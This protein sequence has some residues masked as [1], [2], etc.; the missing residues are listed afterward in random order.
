MEFVNYY[1]QSTCWILTRFLT[2]GNDIINEPSKVF[3]HVIKSEPKRDK[4]ADI[5]ILILSYKWDYDG[6]V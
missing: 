2:N 3:I 5:S 4:V 6:H 1:L